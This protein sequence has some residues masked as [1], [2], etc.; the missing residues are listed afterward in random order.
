MPDSCRPQLTILAANA[1][2]HT[3]RYAVAEAVAENVAKVVGAGL[4]LNLRAGKRAARQAG[5]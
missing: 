5:S 4:E 1:L 2:W 3:R